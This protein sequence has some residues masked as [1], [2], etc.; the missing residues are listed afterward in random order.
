[1]DELMVYLRRGRCKCYKLQDY[2]T[3]FHCKHGDYREIWLE[4]TSDCY[5]RMKDSRWKTIKEKMKEA[6]E[7]INGSLFYEK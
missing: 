3:C 1:M 5:S 4:K 2:K 6:Y 7:I